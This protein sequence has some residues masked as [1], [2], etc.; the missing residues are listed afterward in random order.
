MEGLIKEYQQKFD[1]SILLHNELRHLVRK[2]GDLELQD[3]LKF[4]KERFPMVESISNDREVYRLC[5]TNGYMLSRRITSTVVTVHQS[6]DNRFNLDIF[7]V[8]NKGYVY[9]NKDDDI[10]KAVNQMIPVLCE[11]EK[12][13][14]ELTP[15]AILLACTKRLKK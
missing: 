3:K 10:R 15:D 4:F 6:N 8:Q 14:E 9:E 13:R 12:Y 1:Y 7:E 11:F 5:F 2:C